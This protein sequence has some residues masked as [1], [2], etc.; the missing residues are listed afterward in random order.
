MHELGI[1][2]K[3]YK[4]VGDAPVVDIMA[5]TDYERRLAELRRKQKDIPPTNESA[6]AGRPSKS[7]VE[8]EGNYFQFHIRYFKLMI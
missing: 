1:D 2:G 5:E 3:L 6:P 8:G 7:K 4:A